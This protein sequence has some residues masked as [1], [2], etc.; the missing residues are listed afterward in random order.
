[1]TAIKN[2]DDDDT[3]CSICLEVISYKINNVKD[4]SW[5][6]LSCGHM[7]HK[8][9]LLGWREKSNSYLCPYCTR[10][11]TKEE[12]IIRDMKRYLMK[13]ACMPTSDSN[14]NSHRI[15]VNDKELDPWLQYIHSKGELVFSKTLEDNFPIRRLFEYKYFVSYLSLNPP[16][17]DFIKKMKISLKISTDDGYITPNLSKTYYIWQ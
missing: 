7:Y 8:K 10:D 14:D 12:K 9:C 1:M 6:I 16:L 15:P 17:D 2:D 5:C 3:I 13:L 11:W 4:W